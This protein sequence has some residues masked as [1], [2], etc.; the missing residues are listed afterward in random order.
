MTSVSLEGP[1]WDHLQRFAAE[2]ELPLSRL[3]LSIDEKRQTNLSSA[4]RLYVLY[5]LQLLAAE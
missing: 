5:R 1:F 4:L 3:I 2:D